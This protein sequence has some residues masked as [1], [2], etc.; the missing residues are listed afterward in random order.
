MRVLA[1]SLC[2]LW[3]KR[4]SNRETK[5][6]IGIVSKNLFIIIRKNEPEGNPEGRD[7]NPGLD[8]RGRVHLFPG[9]F[10]VLGDGVAD[11][12][13]ENHIEGP[14]DGDDILGIED[15]RFVPSQVPAAR[16]AGTDG[17]DFVAPDRPFSPEIEPLPV[18]NLGI[19]ERIDG[20]VLGVQTDDHI[21]D[22]GMVKAPLQVRL[23]QVDFPSEERAGKFDRGK[24]H[25]PA[26][27]SQRAV[28]RRPVD[29][30]CDAALVIMPY[31]IP[32]VVVVGGRGLAIN[33]LKALG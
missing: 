14:P 32:I 7:E 1:S 27:G 30:G 5:G 25:R 8:S 3:L 10:P 11:I 26:S 28:N 19:S 33:E 21:L 15:E 20:F 29:T 17:I 16:V 31:A 2:L 6:E 13:E 23:D 9:E 12:V 24:I 22:Q 18:G 4:R